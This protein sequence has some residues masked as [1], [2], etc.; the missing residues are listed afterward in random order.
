MGF[1]SRG[2]V[3]AHRRKRV[4]GG[5][6]WWSTPG[7]AH[8]WGHGHAPTRGHGDATNGSTTRSTPACCSSGERHQRAMERL[9]AASGKA[10]VDRRAPIACVSYLRTCMSATMGSRW[11]PVARAQASVHHDKVA[12]QRSWR[13]ARSTC[14]CMQQSERQW[15]SSSSP[16]PWRANRE[17]T[18]RNRMKEMGVLS[19]L[20]ID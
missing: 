4:G 1:W 5:K 6:W 14:K 9:L 3:G 2:H 20:Q 15:P 10:E 13:R 16:L 18:G 17:R 8:S 7:T 11:F 19:A 12:K